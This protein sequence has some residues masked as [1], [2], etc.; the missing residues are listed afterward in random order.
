[1]TQ[2]ERI[3]DYLKSNPSLSPYEAFLYLGITKLSTRIGELVRDGVRIERKMVTEQNR[4][5][6]NVSY[7]RYRLYD[8]SREQEQ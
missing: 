8:I 6:E 5:G 7:M 1:M 4:Y 2:K 3:M